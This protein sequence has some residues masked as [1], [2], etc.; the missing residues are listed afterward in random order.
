MGELQVLSFEPDL[1]PN[2]ALAWDC[3]I[4][5]CRFVDGPGGLISVFHQSLDAL[6][7]HLIV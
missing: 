2:V 7:C 1:V 5:F 4:S 6:F 3:S